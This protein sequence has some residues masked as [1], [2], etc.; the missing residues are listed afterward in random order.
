MR[1]ALAGRNRRRRAAC[2][3][4][5]AAES[6]SGRRSC[7]TYGGASFAETRMYRKR[8]VRPASAWRCSWGA[9]ST[10]TAPRAPA[11]SS[12]GRW[13]PWGA[14][15]RGAHGVGSGCTAGWAASAEDGS[16][17]S[18]QLRSR[19]ARRHACARR[20]RRTAPWVG[21]ADR[22]SRRTWAA[23]E[24]AYE[25]AWPVRTW[26]KAPRAASTRST[27]RTRL[28]RSG[29]HQGE[30]RPGTRARTDCIAPAARARGGSTPRRPSRRRCG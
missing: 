20:S 5:F 21:A 13:G 26:S 24:R 17:G 28:V 19:R 2:R 9:G 18:V 1:R 25:R 4:L 12:S 29:L 10:R 6:V 27:G 11:G 22:S 7:R 23:C 8:R 16:D 15:R 14:R 3:P 30:P